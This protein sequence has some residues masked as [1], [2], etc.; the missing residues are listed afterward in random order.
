MAIIKRLLIQQVPRVAFL[1]GVNRASRCGDGILTDRALAPFWRQF[2]GLF[3][4]LA[5]NWRFLSLRSRQAY[6]YL[7]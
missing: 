2:P 5:P 6:R 3:A 1:I 4:S 7:P